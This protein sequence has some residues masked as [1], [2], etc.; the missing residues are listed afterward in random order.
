MEI[1]ESPTFA[2]RPP[3]ILPPTAS[4]NFLSMATAISISL[5]SHSGCR[6]RVIFLL[7]DSISGANHENYVE[8]CN[9]LAFLL[10]MTKSSILM[11]SPLDRS[12]RCP[13]TR[14]S[15]ILSSVVHRDSCP[16]RFV[17][18]SRSVVFEVY[19]GQT[20]VWRMLERANSKFHLGFYTRKVKFTQETF[21]EK[22]QAILDGFPRLQDIHPFRKFLFFVPCPGLSHT[23]QT[24]I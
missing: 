24:R 23:R 16:L 9:D 15:W 8:R 1:A 7:S 18:A 2:H 10:P 17:Q 19:S 14:N 13:P 20:P 5:S 22:F 21:G 6:I 4:H 12:L 11:F 3:K